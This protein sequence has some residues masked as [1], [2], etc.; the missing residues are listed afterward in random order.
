MSKKYFFL[1]SLL[2]VSLSFVSCDKDDPEVPEE[3]ELITTVIYTLTPSGGGADITLS[4]KDLDG[5]GMNPPV[6]VGGTLA[7]NET[8]TG[9]LELLNESED[10]AEDITEEIMEEDEDHQFFFQNNIPNLTISYSDQDSNGNPVGLS[11]SLTTGAAASGILTIILRHKPDKFETG[12]SS[13][14]ITNAG[15]ETDIEV[16][17]PIDVE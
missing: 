4:F 7:V 11:N 1:L 16:S 15:G 2:A 5:D 9:A 3:P 8:Y 14:D 6:V 17:F 12:V 13:G 10:P